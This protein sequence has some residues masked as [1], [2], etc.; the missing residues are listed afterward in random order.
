[1]SPP[2]SIVIP[3]WNGADVI[4]DAIRC[5]QAQTLAPNEIIIA[6]DRCDDDTLQLAERAAASD[7]RISVIRHETR[8]GWVRNVN[9][10][11]DRIRGDYFFL[12]FHD[13]LIAPTYLAVLFSALQ[14]HPGARSAF[15]AVEQDSGKKV[16]VD[17]GRSYS[18]G[19]CRRMLDRL[20]LP[21]AGAPLRALTH[22]S[23]LDT[24]LRFPEGSQ[25]GFHA[26][27][28]Y[29]LHL[30]G[31]GDSVYVDEPLYRRRNWREGALTKSWVHTPISELVSDLNVVARSVHDSAAQ[32]LA[33]REEQRLVAHA[34]KARLLPL[35]R[36]VELQQSVE[37]LIPANALLPEQDLSVDFPDR[38]AA[39]FKTLQASA[40]EL[41]QAWSARKA[42]SA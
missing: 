15:V 24:G 33:D 12:Y 13:D 22:R 38:W 18:G 14:S 21:D 23:T 16:W 32:F 36:R 20:L 3:T 37:E 39:P 34:M 40:R 31:A 19:P 1:M 2:I 42:S 28:A 25:K 4:G 6:V 17:R 7:E 27:H 30:M 5:A 41:E 8:V 26:Q 10:A 9:S 11:L 35:L 29:L